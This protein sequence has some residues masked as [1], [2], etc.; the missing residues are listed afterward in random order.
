MDGKYKLF[1][2]WRGLWGAGSLKEVRIKAGTEY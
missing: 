1:K 2:G